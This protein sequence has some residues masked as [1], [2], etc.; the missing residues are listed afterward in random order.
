M[1]ACIGIMLDGNRRWAKKNG[2]PKLEGHRRGYERALECA[3]WVRDRGIKHLAYFVFSTENWNR[4]A[5]EVAYLMKLVEH[6][7]SKNGA[8][9][10]L[11]EEGIRLRFIGKREML[12]ESTQDAMLTAEK[13][14]AQNTQMTLWV[15]ISYGG[16]A[17]IL[18]A[19]KRIA[20]TGEEVTE[21]SFRK[22]FWSAEMPDPDIII[23]TGNVQRLSNFLLW[24]AAYSELFF[25][26]TLWPDFSE[27]MLDRILAEYNKRE[28]RMGR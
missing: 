15:G 3:R 10:R 5:D 8:L 26:D 18:E 12:A 24:Q 9:P 19:A 28:R 21:E 27:E 14:S 23:R 22:H 25:I 11:S 20:K 1:P 2:L 4:E 13:Q 7:V 16:R 6:M 17:E